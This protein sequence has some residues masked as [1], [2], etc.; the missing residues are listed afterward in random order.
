MKLRV[1][2]IDDGKYVNNRS[3]A[4]KV[5]NSIIK[6]QA[7][8]RERH[9]GVYQQGSTL[10]TYMTASI[11]IN[12]AL[13]TLKILKLAQ[14]PTGAL[15]I[16]INFLL[17]SVVEFSILESRTRLEK[18]NTIDRTILEQV[19][20][21]LGLGKLD[22][23]HLIFISERRIGQ[24]IRGFTT[25]TIAAIARELEVILNEEDT[26]A[27]AAR[28]SL[29][30]SRCKDSKI[31]CISKNSNTLARYGIYLRDRKQDSHNRIMD[32][33]GTLHKEKLRPIGY[34]MHKSKVD[35][36]LLGT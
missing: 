28:M 31:G 25:I 35:D 7:T 18:L 21:P 30:R 9:L 19:S 22:S 33:L 29:H 6:Y 32:I 4:I 13:E 24:G 1:H 23:R 20:Q 26:T 11:K 10:D 15:S 36:T 34:Y 16:T 5:N 17:T 12:K 27:I 8:K 3:M 2:F 14:I